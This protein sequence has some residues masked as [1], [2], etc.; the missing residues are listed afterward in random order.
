MALAGTATAAT[1]RNGVCEPGEFCL[2]WGS[3][4]TGSLSDFNTSVPDYGETP[5]CHEF[6]GPGQGRG[7][8]VENNAKS[9]WNRTTS[10]RV[11]VYYDPDDLSGPV[12]VF[13]PGHAG[14]LG[15]TYLHNGGHRFVPAG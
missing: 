5:T 15:A 2:Y 1:P 6:K 14:N 7:Q 12:D 4:L 8:C 13:L 3:G 9:A 10:N 11:I